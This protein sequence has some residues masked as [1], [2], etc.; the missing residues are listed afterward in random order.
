MSKEAEIIKAI[1]EQQGA[2]LAL[3]Q[4]NIISCARAGILT[5][6]YKRAGKTLFYSDG[7]FVVCDDELEEP[8]KS[9]EELLDEV[10]EIT[11]EGN[12][13]KLFSYKAMGKGARKRRSKDFRKRL[14][15]EKR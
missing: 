3:W 11:D 13:D 9:I 5:H 1:E 6:N 12:R 4:K 10:L 14:S 2:P 7:D 8:E 15:Y